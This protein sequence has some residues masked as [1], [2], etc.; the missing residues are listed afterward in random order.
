VY[1][2]DASVDCDSKRYAKL[3]SVEMIFH[4]ILGHPEMAVVNLNSA[5][6]KIKLA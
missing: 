4:V 6:G 2:F 3:T 5:M 1:N